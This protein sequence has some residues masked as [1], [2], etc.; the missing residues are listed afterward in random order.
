MT[1]RCLGEGGGGG[2]GRGKLP[3]D[4]GTIDWC[5]CKHTK[6]RGVCGHAPQKIFD[7]LRWLLVGIGP[8]SSGGSSPLHVDKTMGDEPD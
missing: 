7:S 8:N 5:V 6:T 3:L 2:G 1:E 4:L